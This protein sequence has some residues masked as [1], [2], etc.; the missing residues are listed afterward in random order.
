MGRWGGGF[1][2]E[3]TQVGWAWDLRRE[4]L[5]MFIRDEQKLSVAQSEAGE[6]SGRQITE[7]SCLAKKF[8]MQVERQIQK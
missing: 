4:E 5:R 6:G 3:A 1:L 2:G 8:K 7:P